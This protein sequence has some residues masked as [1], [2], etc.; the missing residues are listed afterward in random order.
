M[1][2]GDLTV[3]TLLMIPVP[4]IIMGVYQGV[5]NGKLVLIGV[6]DVT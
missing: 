1:A 6:N 4:A 5:A 2:I 3:Q